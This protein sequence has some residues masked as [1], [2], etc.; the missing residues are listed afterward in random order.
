MPKAILPACVALLGLAFFLRAHAITALP[1]FI[2]EDNHLYRAADVRALEMHPAQEAQGKLFLYIWLAIFDLNERPTALF[3]GRMTLALT[4]LLTCA[5]VGRVS[6]R[7][8]GASLLAMAI[9][10]L[11]PFAVFFERMVLADPLAGLWGMA[12]LWAAL[13][14]AQSP[15][16]RRGAVMGVCAALAVMSK[17]TAGL[18]VL[19][20]L[21]AWGVAGRPAPARWWR[22]AVYAGLTFVLLWL[23]VLF[24]AWLSLQTETIPD[25]VLVN[26]EWVEEDHPDPLPAK[27]I[28]VWTRTGT[29]FSFPFLGGAVLFIVWGGLR[30][31][32]PMLMVGGALILTWLPS[33]FFADN[34][35]TRYLMNGVPLL[36]VLLGLAATQEQRGLAWVALTLWAGL[37]AL[38]F[39]RTAWDEPAALH[40]PPRDARNY[41][42]D[43]YNAY[44][45]REAL[46]WLN[47]QAEKESLALL[48]LTKLCPLADLY[49]A[50]S[51][52]W[53]CPLGFRAD[54]V[55][56]IAWE[57]Q[58]RA[59]QAQGRV[60]YILTNTL[61]GVPPSPRWVEAATFPKPTGR[62]TVRLWRLERL[63]QDAN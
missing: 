37:F 14:L 17:L 11:T 33:V 34:L 59:W 61:G 44:G 20:G 63:A 6:K 35:S 3:L 45:E 22:S 26:P 5:L 51:I 50:P 21:W 25:Y 16:P 4:G 31:P 49:L 54:E 10:A 42:W 57:G 39:A 30:R 41:L 8:G 38:P 12:T 24:P 55:G 29:L 48:P 46:L 47:A 23:P 13:R 58:A 19:F 40:L 62:Q 60:V 18:V 56:A 27:L 28:S 36:A 1:V 7:L 32:R 53:D 15:S 43:K 2:D 9:Y 52:P